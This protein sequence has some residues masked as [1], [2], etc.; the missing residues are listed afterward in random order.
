M[1]KHSKF[2]WNPC[3]C[4]IFYSKLTDYC[5]ISHLLVTFFMNCF[6]RFCSNFEIL[7]GNRSHR[8]T[9]YQFYNLMS[10]TWVH[11]Q[12]CAMKISCQSKNQSW[13]CVKILKIIGCVTSLI[14]QVKLSM[15]NK[16]GK[17]Q[18]N[19]C[20]SYWEIGAYVWIFTHDWLITVKFHIW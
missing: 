14:K 2:H 19:P 12:N 13:I 16:H 17:F 20:I 4:V 18:W 3:I 8:C 11:S 5:E 9:L 7:L 6:T 15:M 10:E 1:N